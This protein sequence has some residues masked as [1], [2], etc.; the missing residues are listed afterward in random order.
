MLHAWTHTRTCTLSRWLITLIWGRGAESRGPLRGTEETVK[1]FKEAIDLPGSAKHSLS[2]YVME[3]E[4]VRR[5]G[6]EAD[7]LTEKDTAE[8]ER[9]DRARQEE[10]NG[11]SRDR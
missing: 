7:R 3:R 2:V 8:E 11:Q 4:K 5:G 1:G 10:I 9:E 6:E